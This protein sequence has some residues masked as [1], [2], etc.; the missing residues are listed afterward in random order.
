MEINILPEDLVR[1]IKSYIP[2]KFL[3]LTNKYYWK[4][5]YDISYETKITIFLLE[6]YTT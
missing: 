2:I 5:T 6:I 1:I 4:K 3:R